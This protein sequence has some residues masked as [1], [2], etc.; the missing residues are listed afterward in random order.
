MQRNRTRPMWKSSLRM[1]RERVDTIERGPVLDFNFIKAN[2]Y[3]PDLYNPTTVT[4]LTPYNE[5]F[6]YFNG[7]TYSN[8]KA[9]P[10][11][12]S[13]NGFL[14]MKTSQPVGPRF[15]YLVDS[16][17]VPIRT[18]GLNLDSA[19][20]NY[21]QNSRTMSTVDTTY[22][23]VQT[24]VTGAGTLNATGPDGT[25]SAIT[26][27]ATTN[28]GTLTQARG[29]TGIGVGSKH[30]SVWLKRK[31]NGTG[32]IQIRQATT[33]TTVAVT[34]EWKRFSRIETGSPN[35]GILLA[36]SGD[37]VYVYCPQLS[38]SN[39]Q[40]FT[41]PNEVIG[42]TAD[43]LTEGE[44]LTLGLAAS[45]PMSPISGEEGTWFIEVDMT[46]R[47]ANAQYSGGNINVQDG[48]DETW[49]IAFFRDPLTQ[50]LSYVTVSLVMMGEEIY[51]DYLQ[52]GGLSNNILRLALSWST[53]PTEDGVVA[54]AMWNGTDDGPT[55][56]A[57]DPL[58]TSLNLG[59]PGFDIG[60]VNF[61]LKKF[62][63]WDKY[64]S[65]QELQIICNNG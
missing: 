9:G 41:P 10:G 52:V 20:V 13:S 4:L 62:K 40:L 53:R 48:A 37:E 63:M 17:G 45:N 11:F 31:G 14:G 29:T 21:L 15:E 36:N 3:Q 27:T 22:D 5:T 35:C 30:F 51:F 50:A 1:Q 16:I 39:N 58:I 65:P 47:G 38:V 24:G 56:Y 6:R 43:V 49:A 46:D 8:N 34:N 42:D 59:D 33:W 2:S 61:Y 44:A 19:N 25:I 18:L 28:S 55:F 60:G 7:T 26:L 12:I 54:A 23:W 57:N 32:A 64:K